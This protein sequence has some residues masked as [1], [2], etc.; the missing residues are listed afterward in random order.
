MRHNK[1]LALLQGTKN[2]VQESSCLL[3]QW[4]WRATVTITALLLLKELF[5]GRRMQGCTALR[6]LL[7][8]IPKISIDVENV[9]A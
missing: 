9:S 1:E 6:N 2:N 8:P 3:L 4:L 7:K 5:L